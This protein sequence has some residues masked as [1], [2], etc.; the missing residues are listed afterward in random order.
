MAN[1]IDLIASPNTAGHIL[2]IT[3]TQ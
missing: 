1:G 3:V 2:T